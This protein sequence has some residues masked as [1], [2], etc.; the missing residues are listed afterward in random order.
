MTEYDPADDARKSYDFAVEAKR[1]RGD[2]HWPKRLSPQNSEKTSMT[3]TPFDFIAE[4]ITDSLGP[5]CPDHSADC[6]TCEA[7]AEY[8]RLKG[9]AALYD[10]KKPPVVMV[11]DD[12]TAEE[13]LQSTIDHPNAVVMLKRMPDARASAV[14]KAARNL[15]AVRYDTYKARNGNLCSIEGDDGEKAWIVPFDA[16]ADL[17]SALS[18]PD[19]FADAGKLVEGDGRADLERFWRPISEA[20]KSI[21]FEQTFD[22][23]DGKSMTIRNSD[24]YWVRDADGRVYEATWSDHKGGYW[25]DLE[26]ESPVDPVEYMPHPLSLPSAPSKEV[27]GL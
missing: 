25:W 6:P 3:D 9:I 26:G 21:T 11:P 5:R 22:T 23:G 8:D 12:A 13:I 19:H 27:A 4:A 2:K 17:E 15:I 1:Q 7:W 10:Q 20:D 16:M 18:S 24:H 14:E